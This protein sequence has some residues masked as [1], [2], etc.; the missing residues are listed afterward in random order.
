ME[1]MLSLSILTVLGLVLMKLSLNLLQPRQWVIQQTLSDAYLTYE[2][3]Y[4]ERIPFE[5]LLDEDSPWPAF[6]ETDSEDVTVG[7]LPGGEAVT[8]TVTRTR[9]ADSENYPIDGG[10]GTED[11]N[12]A[13]MKIWQVQSVLTYS[14]GSREYVKSR[15]VIR[16]Q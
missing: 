6:P 9:F 8:G 2:R 13:A 3:A 4:S 16:S 15:T 14:V 11:V 7:R 12:P 5:D 10:S 1:A